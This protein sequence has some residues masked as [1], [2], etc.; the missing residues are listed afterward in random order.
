LILVPVIAL[1][2][3]TS[4][5]AQEGESEIRRLQSINTGGG[6][7]IG[8]G[9][10][11][12]IVGIGVVIGGNVTKNANSPNKF[13]DSQSAAEEAK[14]KWYEADHTIMLGGLGY[15]IGIP[16]IIVGAIMKGVTRR[17]LTEMN[18]YLS[19]DVGPNSVAVVYKF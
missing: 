15:E 12:S 11:A 13:Y 4:I 16:V 17:K 3:A 9:V 5:F 2:G 1:I 7:L 10:A 8:L 6:V 14:A 18:R 19:L